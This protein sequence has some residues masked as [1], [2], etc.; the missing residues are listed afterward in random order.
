MAEKKDSLSTSLKKLEK[1]TEWFEEQS[2]IDIEKGIA[3]V[4]EGALLIKETKKNLATIENEF[5]E[6]KK[7]LE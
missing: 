7:S 4:K 3:K 5:E 6:V 1:I 2:E